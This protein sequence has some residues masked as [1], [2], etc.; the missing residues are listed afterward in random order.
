MISSLFDVDTFKNKFFPKEMR[1][2]KKLE[3]IQTKNL[4]N[5]KIKHEK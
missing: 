3:L 5:F 2:F 4:L 1:F